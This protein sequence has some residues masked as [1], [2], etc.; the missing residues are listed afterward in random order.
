M[1]GHK[2]CTVDEVWPE[3]LAIARSV[4]QSMPIATRTVFLLHGFDGLKYGEIADVTGVPIATVEKHMAMALLALTHRLH[5][6]GQ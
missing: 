1:T 6:D 5:G 4:I 2:A 3:D